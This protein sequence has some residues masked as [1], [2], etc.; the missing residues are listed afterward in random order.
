MYV[1]TQWPHGTRVQMARSFGLTLEQVR[2]QV[3]AV[4]G[5]FGGKS[6]GGIREHIATAAAARLLNRPVRYIEQRNDNLQSMQ[7][8]GVHID[9]EA[10][11]TSDG[12]VV[13]LRVDDL[14]DC[15]AYPSTGS[16]EPG[17]TMMMSTG[18]YRIG[19]V[20][21]HARSVMTN[22]PPTGAYRGPGRAEASMVLEQVMDS[23]AHALDLDP[24]TVRSR[25]FMAL[26]ELPKKSITG[27]HYDEADFAQLTERARTTS[28]YERWRDDQRAAPRLGQSQTCWASECHR[29]SI[30]RRGSTAPTRPTCGSPPTVTRWSSSAVRPPDNITTARSPASSATNCACLSIVCA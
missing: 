10:D 4:G 22:L 19:H 6:L 3:P 12:R 26:A 2:A 18:P 15:G 17:K 9:Y 21:F 14:C 7:G 30:R 1:S 8:R 16:V 5:G 13:H 28:D 29:S 27:A 23:V 24:L 11:A 25:N 20:T